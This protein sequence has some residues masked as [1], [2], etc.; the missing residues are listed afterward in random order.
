M[1]TIAEMDAKRGP[2]AL[3]AC[4][5]GKKFRFCHGNATPETTFSGVSTIASGTKSTQQIDAIRADSQ[6]R[7]IPSSTITESG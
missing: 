2:Y 1:E 5:S 7:E 6:S 4:G 3:C